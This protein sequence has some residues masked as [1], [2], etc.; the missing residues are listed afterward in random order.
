MRAKIN[1]TDLKTEQLLELYL[2]QKKSLTLQGLGTFHLNADV[3]IP[4]ETANALLPADAVYFIYDPKVKEDPQLIEF[5]VQQAKKIRPLASADLDSFITLGRQFLNIGKPFIIEGIGTLE[6]NGQEIIF[7]PGAFISPKIE[8]PKVLKEDEHEQRSGLF[9]EQQR[10][11]PPNH[12]RRILSIIALIIVA[13][14]AAW[15]LYNFISGKNKSKQ[16]ILTSTPGDSLVKNISAADST[17]KRDTTKTLSD[18]LHK[19]GFYVVIR[20]NLSQQKAAEKIGLFNRYH[21]N[22]ISFTQDS[23]NYTIAESFDLPLG[24]TSAVKD[25]LSKF[26]GKK[27]FIQPR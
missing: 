10:K 6:K 17:P 24:D 18:T 3:V 5:I 23:V 15:L 14:I 25:S 19:T 26:Y 12:D 16:E 21:H 27:I 2:L 13:G 8:S 4:E 11:S 22:V 1:I 20:E 7:L 9:G